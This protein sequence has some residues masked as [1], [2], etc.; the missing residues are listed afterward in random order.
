MSVVNVGGDIAVPQQS[1]AAISMAVEK[2]MLCKSKL[3]RQTNARR[4]EPLLFYKV[5]GGC[6][7]VINMLTRNVIH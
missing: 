7:K 3:S 5:P 6:A 2:A 1:D 4:R